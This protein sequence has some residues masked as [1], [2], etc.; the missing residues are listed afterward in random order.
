M[1]DMLV[2]ERR[3]GRSHGTHAPERGVAPA[4]STS[5]RGDRPD[6]GDARFP[7]SH[8]WSP[9][10]RRA[11]LG[12]WHGREGACRGAPGRAPPPDVRVG[13]HVAVSP[14][15]VPRFLARF[16]EA[17]G[18][19][20]AAN[21]CWRPPR[22]IIACSGSTRSSMATAASPVSSRTPCCRRCST[23]RGALCSPPAPSRAGRTGTT[24]WN[25]RQSAVR[26]GSGS[27][28]PA[29][30]PAGTTSPT[31]QPEL[32]KRSRGSPTSSSR[33]ASTSS[34][35]ACPTTRAIRRSRPSGSSCRPDM[36]ANP[37]P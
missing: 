8:C 32:M 12:R 19:L 33:S 27:C 23:C 34:R 10:P 2:A 3:V 15:A 36:L 30:H 13:R 24:A 29:T 21:V 6:G 1:A 4:T 20:A 17:Y 28:A 26:Q 14:G 31:R 7:A 22:P 35:R 18:G 37:K 5:G 25:S 9:P 11:S 16:E